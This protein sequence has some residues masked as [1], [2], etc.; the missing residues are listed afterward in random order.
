VVISKVPASL[1]TTEVEGH[2]GLVLQ[3]GP[4]EFTV[5]PDLGLL[6]TSLRHRGREYLVLRGG[7]TAVLAGHT[8][9]L[10]LLA[11]WANRVSADGYRVRR[12]EVDLRRASGLHRDANG[13]PIHGTMLGRAGWVIDRA[14]AV[15]GYARIGARFD[16]AADDE[17]MASFPFPHELTV[18]M[19]VRPGDLEVITTLAPT[20]RA[21]VPASFGWHPYFELPAEEPDD[22]RIHLPTGD[23]LLLDDRMLPTGKEVT[24]YSRTAP[25]VAPRYDHL[26]RLRSNHRILAV[27]GRRRQLTMTMDPGYRYGQVYSPAGESFVALE[28]MVAPIDALGEGTAPIVE[29]GQSHRA[30]FRLTLT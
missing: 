11:P 29:R 9:G 24:G 4:T 28:P 13:M 7:A 10:P 17:V 22:L 18:T 2:G 1:V 26:Y 27:A 14:E 23:Q 30:R 3:A 20:G 19:R 8:T 21:G 12:T 16:A 6:G 15:Q 25:L 5:V